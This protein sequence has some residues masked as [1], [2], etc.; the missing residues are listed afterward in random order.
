MKLIF[1]TIFAVL[2]INGIVS[3]QNFSI[4]ARTGMGNTMDLRS[5]RNGVIDKTWDKELFFRYE[6]K[7]RLAFEASGTQYKYGYNYG[8]FISECAPWFPPTGEDLGGSMKYNM[9]DISLSAQ[10]NITCSYMQEHCPMFK[11]LKSFLGVSIGAAYERTTM[12][13]TSRQFSDG[14]IIN[15]VAKGSGI[16]N[17]QIGINHT[18]TYSLKH[19]YLTT[20]AAYTVQPGNTTQ[21]TFSTD[22]YPNSKFSARIGVGYRL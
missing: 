14:Q 13:N 16:V 12:T 11:N 6:T 20:V 3:A 8:P 19:L 7:G 9:I 22:G 21:Y 10:Y 4:G 1:T 2:F 15:D 18:L 17:P 5:M